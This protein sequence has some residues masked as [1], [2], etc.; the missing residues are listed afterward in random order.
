MRTLR[1]DWT[2][3]DPVIT[4]ELARLGRSGVPVYV[5]YPPRGTPILL[6]EVLTVDLVREVLGRLPGAP[7]SAGDAGR[8][9]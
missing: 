4:A 7:G 3:H 6:P 9:S 5:F 8:S 2:L 1:A